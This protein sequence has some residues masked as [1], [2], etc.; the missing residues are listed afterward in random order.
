MTAASEDLG[1]GV[2]AATAAATLVPYVPRLLSHWPDGVDRLDAEGTLVSADLSGFTRLS[3]R[4]ASIGREGAEELTTLLNGC[5]TRMIAEVERYGGDV[6]KFGGDALLIQYRGPAHT[7]RACFSTVA[8]RNLI[9]EPLMTSTGMRVRLRISQGLHAGTFSCFV[10]QGNHRELMVTGP[11]VTETVDCEGTAV[12]GQILLSS[13][14]AANVQPSWLG[15]ELDGQRR[16]LRRVVSV[17]EQIDMTTAADAP[18]AIADFVPAVQREQIAAGAQS[19]HRRVT[20]GFVKFSHTDELLLAGQGDVLAARLQ[21]LAGAVARA[22]HDFGVHW[23]ASDVYPDGGK[24]ILTA[25]APV[26]LGDDEER[27][28]R[29]ARFILDEVK[30]LDLR[31]GVNVGPVFVGNLGS[32]SRRAFTVMGDAVNLAAR[33]M[34]KAESG[35]LVASDATIERSLTRFETEELEPFFVKGKT[36]PIRASIVGAAQARRE[37]VAMLDLIGRDAELQILLDG[38]SSARAGSG[39]IVEIVGEPGAGKSRLLQELRRRAAD[40]AVLGVQCGQ[41]AR[42]SP[43]FAVRSMLR[44]V[45]GIPGDASPDDAAEVLSAFVDDVAPEL[46]ADLPLLAIPFDADIAPT[47]AVLRIAPQFR[48][49]RSHVAAANLIAAAVREP[50][51]LLIE[52]LHW[53]D[54]A[55]RDLLSELLTRIDDQPWL[56]VLTRRPGPAPIDIGDRPRV[57]LQPLDADAALELVLAAAGES[58]GLRPADWQHL[59]ERAGGNPLFAIELAAAARDQGSADALADSVESLVTSR[60][61]RLAAR[62]RLLLR[63]GSVQGAIVDVDLLAEALDDDTVRSA[64]RWRPLDDFVVADNGVLRFRHAIHQHVAYEGLSYRRRREM[65]GRVARAIRRRWSEPPESVVGLLSTHYSRAGEHDS[66]WEFSVRAGDDARSKYAHVE[67]AEFYARALDAARHLATVEDVAI[68]AVAESLGDV[69]DLTSEYDRAKDAYATARKHLDETSPQQA[70]LLRKAGRVLEREGRYTTA[71]R[72]FSRALKALEELGVTTSSTRA[73]LFAAYGAVRYRQGRLREASEWAGRAIVEGEAAKELPALAHAYLLMGLCLEDL[74]DPRRFDYRTRALPLYEQLDDQVGLADAL[75]NLGAFLV[76]DG[77]LEEARQVIERSVQARQRAGDIIGEAGCINN[78]GEVLIAQGRA[79]EARGYLQHAA[80]IVRSAS[81]KMAT[82]IV[83]CSLGRAEL[84]DGDVDSGAALIDEATD[85]AV[86]INA[87]F[88]A[89]EFRVRKLQALVETGYNDPATALMQDLAPL[90]DTEQLE[91]QFTVVLPRLDAWLALRRGDVDHAAACVQL[92]LDRLGSLETMELALVLRA[93]AEI[94]RRQC[95]PGAE[96]DD[97]RD[98]ELC[99]ANG[100]EST[101]PLL[102][103]RPLFEK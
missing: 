103:D 9:A 71:L 82:A 69:R 101:P 74:G 66:A 18:A 23:L 57:E 53:V 77:K 52:D 36:V 43:Y 86:E 13:A 95:E 38:A 44:S 91:Q 39:Q 64:D 1:S 55:S 56:A 79:H 37:Q 76:A 78:L 24:V 83:L 31:I 10:L 7:E 59:V 19:E 46:A 80:R 30:G 12:A 70:E 27:M 22:E 68:A 99:A 20:V 98:A 89:N 47:P 90:G 11:G 6:L 100:V 34:Q 62:D 33:L 54:D 48:R 51:L 85:L 84:M 93:R 41:Y 45:T 32:P 81:Y 29:A 15:R 87:A 16:L 26:S 17:D 102:L 63:E 65:H 3:E 4:L 40:L 88:L 5:F 61:D 96:E 94:R 35:Q 73:A 25:G 58:S 2:A 97:A 72:Y 42:S 67:A 50:T 14:A 49:A 21:A 28:L 75:T 60:I 8:M 92:A